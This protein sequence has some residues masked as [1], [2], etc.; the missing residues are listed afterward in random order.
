MNFRFLFAFIIPLLGC[1]N[2][3]EMNSENKRMDKIEYSYCNNNNQ[4]LGP[5]EKKCIIRIY[6]DED[7]YFMR[8]ILRNISLLKQNNNLFQNVPDSSY[9]E[10]N[11][12]QGGNVYT[13]STSELYITNKEAGS[14]NTETAH[15][16]L[17]FFTKRMKQH[18]G[19]YFLNNKRIENERNM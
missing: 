18:W 15:L 16:L 1:D 2:N 4:L 8:K 6:S 19:E 3:K 5:Y 17:T 11:I 12:T 7:D 14:L 10:F 9:F 13:F